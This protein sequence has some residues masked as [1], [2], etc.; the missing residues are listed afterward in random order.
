MPE[1]KDVVDAAELAELLQFLSQWLARDPARLGDSL[2]QFV[3][4]PAY[5]LDELRGDLE[6][7]VFLLGGSDGDPSSAH[8]CDS[9]PAE[10]TPG[11]AGLNVVRPR[12]ARCG[13]CTLTP[14]TA[15]AFTSTYPGQVH[16]PQRGTR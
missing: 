8:D 13:R 1:M 3:G 9:R 5:G 11:L 2:A 14:A 7:F 10:T 15:P 6:R 4:H 16:K 12:A